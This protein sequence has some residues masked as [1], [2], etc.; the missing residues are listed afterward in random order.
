[1][2]YRHRLNF[3]AKTDSWMDKQ[4][5][6]DH[7]GSIENFVNYMTDEWSRE[8]TPDK[9]VS[10]FKE[11]DVDVTVIEIVNV[12]G[13]HIEYQGR[14]QFIS[15]SEVIVETE[16]EFITSPIA[17]IV[18][19]AIGIAIALIIGAITIPPVFFDWLKSMT[20]E[21]ITTTTYV[22][23]PETGEWVPKKEETWTKPS[24]IGI[25]SVGLIM[26]ILLAIFLIF[27]VGMPKR[28]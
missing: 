10:A 19:I 5:I 21:T 17:V 3:R 4:Y 20:T 16:T 22:Q 12:V 23:D 26:I 18:I 25:G 8:L 7:F 14:I 6:L 24:P 13:G 27:M 9:I 11:Q 15:I 28:R 1:M 2:T